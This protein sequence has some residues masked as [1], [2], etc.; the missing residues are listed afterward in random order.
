MYYTHIIH[1][2]NITQVDIKGEE[3]KEKSIRE[4]DIF[5]LPTVLLC[6]FLKI[7]L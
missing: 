6:H 4:V 7:R 2:L 5:H 1:Q 3:K